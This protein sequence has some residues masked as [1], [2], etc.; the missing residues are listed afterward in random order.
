MPGGMRPVRAHVTISAPREEVYDF[1]ADL[2]NRVAWCDQ[3]QREFRLTR[4]RSSGEG[5]AARFHMKMRLNHTWVETAVVEAA[6][7]RVLRE[8]LRL[9][10]LGRT[11]GFAEYTFEPVGSAAT[12]IEL[13]LWTEP[14]TR[15][16][17]FKESLG[18]R[19]WLRRQ[20]KASL[21]RLRK[22]F[23]E[24]PEAPLA[25]ATIAGFE[26]A[27]AARFGSF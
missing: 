11:P 1:V 7:P 8:T 9:Y 23:E 12:R 13:V 17:A 3:Y 4:P 27:K 5:A 14:A 2:A 10:R 15:L 21:S 6:R 19:R 24:R 18:G 22:I 20:V 26:P 25:R 16:D